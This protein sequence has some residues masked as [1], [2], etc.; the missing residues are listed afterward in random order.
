MTSYPLNQ[1]LSKILSYLFHPSLI[2]LLFAA[3]IIAEPSVKISRA[4]AVFLFAAIAAGTYVFPGL[5]AV[6]LYRI[7][8]IGSLFMHKKEERRIPYLLG[9]IF[10]YFTAVAVSW[11]TPARLI[12][13]FLIGT[14][15][16]ILILLIQIPFH[17]ASA[18][19]AALSS[20]MAAVLV[21]SRHY[22]WSHWYLIAL[23]LATG[24]V[25]WARLEI[26]AHTVG[27]VIAGFL[28]GFIPIF[29]LFSLLVS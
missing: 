10:Y 1:T 16:V 22:G 12:Y 26:N 27:E 21:L 9:A 29:T 15:I 19:V 25:G 11:V 3:L 2:P 4:Q 8:V 6:F 28:S 7:G 23:V 24:L 20:M 14:C 5:L 18:H 17:K 13:L